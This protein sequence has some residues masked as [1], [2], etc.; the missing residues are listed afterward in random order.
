MSSA[1]AKKGEKWVQSSCKQ[2]LAGCSIRVQVKDGIVT[3]IEGDPTSP[4][5]LGKLCTK[6]QAGLLRLYDPNRIK[7]PVK[8]TNPQK[9]P[10]I[11]PKWQEISWEEAFDIVCTKLKQV[12][13]KDPR[14]LFFAVGDFLRLWY[15]A[16]AFAFGSPHWLS[17][18]GQ[19]CGAAYHPING[20]FHGALA[21]ANDYDYCNYWIQC[22][23]GDGFSSHIG[24][25]GS[26]KRMADA[27][28]RGMKVVYV[29][30]RLSNGAA[31]A[32]EWIPI[33][34]GTDRAFLLG[35]AYVLVFETGQYDS[36]FLKK[37]TN[38]PYL[39]GPD[40]YYV[41]DKETDKPL[42]WDAIDGQA[43][44]WDD[45]TI[46]DFA[47]TGKY[48]VD[49]VECRPA[50]Q[51]FKDI[52]KDHTPERM[53]E[54]TTIP[55]ETIR[56]IAKEYAD[57]AK[58]GS[59]IE[60]DGIEFPYRPAGVNGYRGLVSHKN[61][62]LD[63]M[64][65][66]VINCL[67]GNIDA[68]GGYMGTPLDHRDIIILPG[69]DGLIEP[70]PHMLHPEYPFKYPPDSAHYMEFFPL[71]VD[72]G[73]LNAV[74]LLD[75][76]KWKIDSKPEVLLC[77][78]SNPLWNIPGTDR[79]MEIMKQFDMIIAIDVVPNETTEWA[80]I[81][82]P[83]HTYLESTLI[84]FCDVPVIQGHMCR[85][86]AVEPLYNTK[87][88]ADI[89][90]EIA[91]RIGMLDTWIDVLNFRF[92][93]IDKPEYML[94]HGRKYTEEEVM[95]TFARSLYGDDH[96]LEWF[97][98]NG[99]NV[100]KKPPR[101]FYRPWE[102]LRLPFYFEHV[103]KVGDEF[104]EKLK[105]AGI[106]WWPTDNYVPLPFWKPSPIHTESKE[107][108]LYAIT[109][110]TPELNFAENTTIPWIREIC[111]RAP[112]HAGVLINPETAKAR[113]IN[114]GDRIVIE[115][116]ES[117]I[118]GIAKLTEGIH[119]Q[120]I[121]VS[122]GITRWTI[123]PVERRINTHFNKLLTPTLEYTCEQSGAIETAARVR[124]RKK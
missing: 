22:G 37:D 30:P 57:A 16:F 20:I 38:A 23:A 90:M 123:N 51:V 71:G 64:T 106:D 59:K 29:E 68:P 120:V 96:G 33:L 85:Q 21:C 98:R 47:L 91:D 11:D 31:K 81:I 36:E 41:R 48:V 112:L 74:T 113:G 121:G 27:R 119:P 62:A 61:G 10:G 60:L 46:K 9:G 93:F 42:V 111:E 66:K 25:A 82:L 107:Y 34:P 92:G 117:S 24:L 104:K 118:E 88:A 1:I 124:V 19:Y 32:D 12:R 99:H 105:E 122:T 73:H 89:L 54:I 3:K 75:R 65:L 50:F 103:K 87:D 26:Q 39:I 35:M 55:A 67:V 63:I 100:Y 84:N 5:N 58:I 2:C 86:P 79:V 44:T 116:R 115:S 28:M 4:H 110:K 83:D 108:D 6:G 7:A 15:W 53:S 114:D 80:D 45:P 78:H 40:G 52:L 69:K 14:G 97:K 109:F 43:K 76:S 95:D 101:E 17:T 70:V 8:R 72:P 94:Q 77:Y 13:E 102:G 49:G 18:V 56:R